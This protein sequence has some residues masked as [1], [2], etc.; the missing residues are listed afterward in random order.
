MTPTVLR[1]SG[2]FYKPT[3]LYKKDKKAFTK[4]YREKFKL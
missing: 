3:K 1:D 2:F 4:E